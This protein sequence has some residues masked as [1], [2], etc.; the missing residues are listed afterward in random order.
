MFLL[1]LV[2]FPFQKVYFL[3]ILII[4]QAQHLIYLFHH[5]INSIFFSYLFFLYL[6][7]HLFTYNLLFIIS[8]FI[9]KH[10]FHFIT[11]HYLILLYLIIL[12]Y[13][14]LFLH[15]IYILQVM[16]LIIVYFINYYFPF[17]FSSNL[18]LNSFFPLLISQYNFFNLLMHF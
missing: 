11:Y 18:I 5:L 8:S 14:H 4:I 6:H 12:D 1:H 17:N 13:Y 15:F 7:H 16:M 2:S 9:L 3:P 10:Q